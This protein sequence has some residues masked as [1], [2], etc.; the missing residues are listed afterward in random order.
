MQTHHAPTRGAARSSQQRLQAAHR[1]LYQC[2]KV[3][4]MCLKNT[5]GVH[6]YSPIAT[7]GAPRSRYR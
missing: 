6:I 4:R 2:K 1:G 3:L 5:C 7:A